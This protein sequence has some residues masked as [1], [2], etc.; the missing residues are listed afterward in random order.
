MKEYKNLI[1]GK[2]VDSQ[3]GRKYENRNPA[4]WDEVVG[5]FPK[6]N[7]D[8]LN[9][10][11]E[12]AQKAYKKWRRVPWPKRSEI[13]RKVANIM[14][15]KKEEVAQLMTKHAVMSRKALIQHTMHLL[16]AGSSSDI[17][18]LQNYQTSPA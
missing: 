7:G 6:S 9:T 15:Q 14:M 18:F 11:I 12:A 16:R 4:N 3:S 1:N 8:D 17:P 2:F 10:A 5:I 13:M